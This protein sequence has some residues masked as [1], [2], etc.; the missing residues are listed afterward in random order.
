MTLLG[1]GAMTGLIRWEASPPA[2]GGEVRRNSAQ[3]NSELELGRCPLRLAMRA[4]E[5]GIWDFDLAPNVL[6][7]S[8]RMW[9]HSQELFLVCD[10]QGIVRAANPA[11]T[12]ILGWQ[13]ADLLGRNHL[14]FVGPD[15]CDANAAAFGASL[16]G[17]PS[18]CESRM[19]HKDGSTRW[20][21]WMVSPDEGLIH[22][23]GRHVTAEKEAAQALA[24]AEKQV[25]QSRKMQAV[26]QLTGGIAHDFNNLLAGIIGNLEL[27]QRR[28]ATGRLDG[29]DRYAG[30]ATASAER[31]AALTQRLLAFARPQ[32]PGPKRVE[33]N[34]L[35]SGMEDLLR[36]ALE[37]AVSLEM[38]FAGALWPTLCDPNQLENAILNLAINARDAMPKGG[39]LTVETANAYLDDAYAEV[40]SNARA[41]QYVTIAVT[42]TGVGMGPEVVA[43]AFDPFFTTKPTGQGTGLGLSM[44]YD[45]VKQS[46]GHVRIDSEPGLGTTFRIYLPRCRGEP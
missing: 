29:L 46:D 33:A 14:D 32:P 39:R 2:A 11:W 40:P 16:A 36:R 26:G 20:I 22:A 38:V 1:E 44:L 18:H 45:F 43:K 10:R 3:I 41:G 24:H 15:D 37:P 27:L 5:I 35:L 28:I 21:A 31:A 17:G 30:M 4:A 12:R 8:D 42:D 13:P 6:A 19:R 9:R 34:W 25:R 7:W 23:S